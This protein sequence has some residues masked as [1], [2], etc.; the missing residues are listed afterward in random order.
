MRGIHSAVV[1]LTI[2]AGAS[3]VHAGLF[4]FGKDCTDCCDSQ[5]CQPVIARPCHVNTMSHQRQ[6][7][8]VPCGDS[9]CAPDCCAP[10]TCCAPTEC[11]APVACGT[12]VEPQ[13]CAPVSC[14]AP[15]ACE[16]GSLCAVDGCCG[17][18]ER[19][20]RDDRC[21]IAALIRTSR[22]ACYAAQ[23]RNAV[24]HLS[25]YYDCCCHPEIMAALVFAL[26]DS[27]HRVRAKA[28]DEIGDQ[29]RVNRCICGPSVICALRYSLADCDRCVR[30]Q[31]EEAL[32]L[33]GYR[34]VDGC[35][36]CSSRVSTS[37]ADHSHSHGQPTPPE[38]PGLPDDSSSAGPTTSDT[39]EIPVLPPVDS[40]EPAAD[41]S[42]SESAAESDMNSDAETIPPPERLSDPVSGD[43]KVGA[44]LPPVNYLP[45]QFH[46]QYLPI[47][48]PLGAN[49]D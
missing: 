29:I 16:Q 18:C 6:C 13:C 44:E 30:R 39:E 27:D 3:Q 8:P 10:V 19:C 33:C 22:T 26:N 31:A 47:R 43:D 7:C 20:C 38:I 28:A 25:D 35:Y 2:L 15:A 36:V 17:G 41:A 21:E 34:I 42:E 12:T 45:A 23:R 46:R 1:M 24:H 32:M 11:C 49:A 37:A 48:N 9:A 5:C 40:L 4:G 14:C